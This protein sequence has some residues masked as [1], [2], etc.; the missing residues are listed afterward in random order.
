[1]DSEHVV[2]NMSDSVEISDENTTN[3]SDDTDDVGDANFPM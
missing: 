1:M 3:T 2:V